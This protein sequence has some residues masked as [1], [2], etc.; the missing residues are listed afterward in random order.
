MSYSKCKRWHN[1]K[2]LNYIRNM[3][4]KINW[5]KTMYKYILLN[6]YD[7]H[8]VIIHC[9]NF[10]HNTWIFTKQL[11]TIKLI[12]KTNL[13]ILNLKLFE[14][15]TRKIQE[16]FLFWAKKLD[17]FTSV[18]KVSKVVLRQLKIINKSNLFFAEFML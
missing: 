12:S 15:L 3:W 16:H 1:S 7:I 5:M 13:N 6:Q 9:C 2:Y 18:Y 11:Y 14:W 4:I 10:S 17:V 8:I